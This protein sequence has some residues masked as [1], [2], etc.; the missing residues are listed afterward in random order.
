MC[1][2]TDT[3]E[4][5]PEYLCDSLIKPPEEEECNVD[6]CRVRPK[7]NL[8]NWTVHII[9]LYLQ[10]EW[11]TGEWSDCGSAENASDSCPAISVRN[12][13]CEQVC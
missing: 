13:Y 7:F 9:L 3:L 1:K 10:P 4:T 8:H 6:A 12:V 2:Q 11:K 5:V